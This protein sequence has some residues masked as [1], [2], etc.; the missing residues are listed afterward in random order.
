MDTKKREGEREKVME[1]GREICTCRGVMVLLL[2]VVQIRQ[3]RTIPG[4]T[5]ATRLYGRVFA[6][7]KIV[8][9]SRNSIH[10]FLSST[11]ARA[12]SRPPFHTSLGRGTLLPS[13]GKNSSYLAR[14]RVP[15]ILISGN[16]FSLRMCYAGTLMR[17]AKK[18]KIR[19]SENSVALNVNVI[20][21]ILL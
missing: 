11:R 4:L 6:S 14:E 13:Q 18:R 16:S 21:V 1:K 17:P 15:R 7:R 10:P 8:D 9:F 20:Y 3:S 12:S 5:H 2:T 19:S